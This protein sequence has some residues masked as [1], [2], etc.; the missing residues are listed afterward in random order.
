MTVSIMRHMNF[1]TQTFVRF[2]KKGIFQNRMLT[3]P[4]SLHLFYN[5]KP[6]FA[7]GSMGN[8]DPSKQYYLLAPKNF[9]VR[10]LI[11]PQEFP[12]ST[13]SVNID[14]DRIPSNI[15]QHC[16]QLSNVFDHSLN[17]KV[18]KTYNV[19]ASQDCTHSK[20]LFLT[21]RSQSVFR[22][23]TIRIFHKMHLMLELPLTENF[24]KNQS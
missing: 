9:L 10:P 24:S 1:M 8:Y 23:N 20:L 7:I 13:E 16:R 17:S 15:S 6:S 11:I 2:N 18:L 21:K 12:I 5:L 19:I 3:S 22:R 4:F 14:P